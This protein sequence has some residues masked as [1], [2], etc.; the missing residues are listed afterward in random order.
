MD[1][2]QT[3]S[4]IW[5]GRLS[6][7]EPVDLVSPASRDR[8]WPATSS[9]LAAATRSSLFLSGVPRQFAINCKK[10]GGPDPSGSTGSHPVRLST[11]GRSC[12]HFHRRRPECMP[13]SIARISTSGGMG[14]RLRS[15]SLPLARWAARF[16]ENL[17]SSAICSSHSCDLIKFLLDASFF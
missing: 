14:C 4:G 9:M 3:M 12:P 17:Q 11:L 2:A 5:A 16:G 6:A 8:K 10:G 1:P 15:S 13:G 7:V